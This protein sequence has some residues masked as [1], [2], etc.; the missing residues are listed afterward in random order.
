MTEAQK[1][2]DL[3]RKGDLERKRVHWIHA[4]VKINMKS[5]AMEYMKREYITSGLSV[6]ELEW[7]KHLKST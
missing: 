2:W 3:E 7:K 5:R 1:K 4:C 6:E